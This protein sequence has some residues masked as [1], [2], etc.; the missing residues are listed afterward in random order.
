MILV[1]EFASLMS[2]D[3]GTP[4]LAIQWLANGGGGGC[5]FFARPGDHNLSVGIPHIAVTHL[6]H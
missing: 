5:I 4:D 2:L 3:Q 1:M 6:H